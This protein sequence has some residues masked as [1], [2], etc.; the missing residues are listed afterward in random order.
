MMAPIFP[1]AGAAVVGNN[2]IFVGVVQ[3]RYS[4]S[5]ENHVCNTSRRVARF[6]AVP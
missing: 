3:K 5:A 1:G 2:D 6:K 4:W